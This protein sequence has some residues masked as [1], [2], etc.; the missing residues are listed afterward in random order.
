LIWARVAERRKQ[1]GF[2]CKNPLKKSYLLWV[3]GQGDGKP[4]FAGGG[5]VPEGVC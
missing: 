2:F 4:V 1:S 5:K 3:F